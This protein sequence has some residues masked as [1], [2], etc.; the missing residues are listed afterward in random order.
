MKLDDFFQDATLVKKVT[1]KII[2]ILTYAIV[3][4]FALFNLEKLRD[5][6]F[7]ALG[8]AGPFLLGIALA[9]ILNVLVKLF[10][11]RVLSA[12]NKTKLKI[13]PKLRRVVAIILSFMIL[14]LLVLGIVFFVIPELGRSLTVLKD[15]IPGYINQMS[16]WIMKWLRE[17]NI[18]QEQINALKI[19]WASLLNQATQFTTNFVGSLFNVT[20]TVAN[21]VFTTSMGFIF[22]VYM[23]YNK[24]KITRNLKRITYAYLPRRR[25]KK[26]ID[27]CILSNRIFSSFVRGQLTESLILGCLCY[28]GMTILQLPYA[29]LIGS[30]VA[31]ASL[32]PILGAWI[33]VIV[34]GFILLLVKPV[35]GLTFVIFLL[36]LQQFEGNVIYPRVVGTSV[37]LPGIWVLFAI[38]VCGNLFGMVGILLG[39]PTCS[40]LYTL[41][42]GDTKKRLQKKGIT[43]E[44]VLANNPDSEPDQKGIEEGGKSES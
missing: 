18:T 15:S 2:L 4:I 19:D 30:V 21:G 39:I 22:S 13:W 35:Y 36:I 5:L 1:K 28:A 17:F 6:F 20:M 33:G 12:F 34:G 27:V 3:L 10:E 37:G 8:L 7:G 9:Y 29:L 43:T 25:A 44:Q 26:I 23:L 32:I 24:E 38:I 16:D 11:E 41:L 42:R 40:V 14:I 31:I